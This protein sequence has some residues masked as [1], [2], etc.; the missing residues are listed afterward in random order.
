M[1]L[2]KHEV[3]AVKARAF[4]YLRPGVLDEAVALLGDHAGSALAAARAI[5]AGDAGWTSI[6]SMRRVAR[7]EI[8]RLQR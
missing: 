1:N 5:V 8:V 4:L 7:K 2:G 6:G 3:V